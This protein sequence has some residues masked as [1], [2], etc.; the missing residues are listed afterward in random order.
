[1]GVSFLFDFNGV[2]IDDERVHWA[3]MAE[4]A[5]PLGIDLSEEEYFR[6]VIVFDDWGAFGHILRSRGRSATAGE[7]DALVQAKRPVYLRIAEKEARH[8]PGAAELLHAAASVGTVGIV[9]GA[10]RDEI[11]LA[12][13]A[14][15]ARDAVRFVVSAEDTTRGK[16]DPEGYVVGRRLAG[17]LGAT[18]LI[19]V[20]DS[21]GG[22][23]AARLA[24]LPACGVATSATE[25]A[26]LRAGAVRVVHDLASLT[27]ADLAA[28]ARPPTA[29]G[30]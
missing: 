10:L 17:D 11:E 25:D 27:A 16:P 18:E 22:V 14:M 4:V 6:D 12:L 21:P 23:E 2:L 5:R 15:G 7:V 13:R 20:E 26:L 24:G 9:S 30:R 1:M 29:G 3:A 8:Y 19:V 28:L